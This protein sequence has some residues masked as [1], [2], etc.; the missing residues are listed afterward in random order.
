MRWITFSRTLGAKGTDVA[1]GV[2]VERDYPLYDAAA[3]SQMAE[4]LGFP[5]S[6]READEKT[7]S[8]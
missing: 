1:R 3:I 8:M 7:P 5:E 6:V 2:A 4:Q